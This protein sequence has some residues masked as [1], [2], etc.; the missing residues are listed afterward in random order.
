MAGRGREG[1]RTRRKL[2]DLYL[3]GLVRLPGHHRGRAGALVADD[4]QGRPSGGRPT[5]PRRWRRGPRPGP[6]GIA[7]HLDRVPVLLLLLVDLRTLAAVDRDADRYTF[8]GGAS[9]YPFAW[10]VLLAARAEGLGG[11]M[12]TMPIRREDEVKALV[13]AGADVAVAALLAL[14][15]PRVRPT[16][17]RRRAVADFTTVDR[18]N[19]PTF[20]PG[21]AAADHQ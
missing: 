5:G 9:V 11:V 16:H 6:G 3:G 2:R 12:T 1:S 14:G 21:A 19:G 8:A 10:S 20:A 17:L 13:G 15:H 4:R 7:E 18:L